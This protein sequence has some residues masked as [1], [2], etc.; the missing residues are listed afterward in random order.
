MSGSAVIVG[1]GIFGSSLAYRLARD[2][3]DVTLY[4]QHEPGHERAASGGES[5]LIRYAHGSDA[6]YTR[7]AWRARQLWRELE[8]ETGR[9]LLVE[10]G[11]VWFARSEDGWEAK[12]E[13]VL[14]AEGIPVDRLPA[15][16]GHRFFPSF[17]PGGLEFIV[18]E[19]EAGVLR[20][21]A[22][23]LATAEAAQSAGVRLLREAAEPGRLE[24]DAV[25]WACGAWLASLFPGLVQLR[26]TRQDLFFLRA[27]E[28]WC[29]PPVPAWVDYDRA[30]YGLGDLDGIGVKVAPDLEGP[31]FDPETGDRTPNPANERAARAYAAERF[32]AL[33]NAPLGLAKVCQYSLTPDTNF[34]LAPHPALP[35]NWIFGGGSGHGFKH[36]P[37]L[38]EYAARVVS[39]EEEPDERFG[40]GPRGRGPSLRTAGTT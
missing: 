12:S 3:W 40:L 32:P 13:R 6:W 26:V 2:G 28:E 24:A 23:T 30:V 14:R 29:T 17:D 37:A 21:A 31:D 33:A 8:T 9:E 11:I 5:R 35:H 4:E 15:E 39:G 25:V 36:G 18:R 38:A 10:C 19:P 20:A 27:G 1:A 7:S 34:V 16:E 22:A